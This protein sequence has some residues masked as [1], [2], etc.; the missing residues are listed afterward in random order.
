MCQK[1]PHFLRND[2]SLLEGF[3]MRVRRQIFSSL[4]ACF[5]LCA[6]VLLLSSVAPV[7]AQSTSTGTVV[8]NVTDPSGAVVSG[9][10][11][12]LTNTSTK[13]ART[14]PTNQAGRYIFVDVDPGTYDLTISKQGFSTSKTQATVNV[15][16]ATTVNM[17]LQ[18]GGSNVVVEVTAAGTE[19]QTMNATVGNTVSSLELD[20]L[21]SLGRDT[22]TFIT[23]QPGVSPDGSVAGAV[24]DQSYFS[25]DGGNNTNDMDGSM[26]V[27]TASYAGD[28][29][30]GI[31]N[32]SNGV[33]AGATGVMPTPQDSVEEFKVN[34]AGQT[35]DFNSSAGAEVKVV[36]KRGTNAIHGTAYEYYRDN[37][38]SGNTWDNSFNK[39]GLPTF[40][41]SR[42]GFAAGGP[43]IPKDILGGR[44]YLFG[45]FEGFRYPNS[46]TINRNVPSPALIAGN[47]TD[48]TTGAVTSLLSIDPNHIGINPVVQQMWQKYEPHSNANCVLSLCDGVNILGYS[49]NVSL[50]QKSNFAVGRLDHDFSD[51]WH[52]MTSYRYYNLSHAT[53]DQVDI[54]GFF[55]GDKLG[56][57][58]SQSSDPQQAWYLVAGLTTNITTNTTNDIHYSFLRNWW[59][60]SRAGDTP[61]LPGLGGALE[62][63]AGESSTQGLA[64]FNVNTQNTRT[65][66]WDGHD[67]MIRDDLSMLKGNHLFQVGGTY[68]HNFNWHQRSDNGGGINFQPVYQMG[69]GGAGSGLSSDLSFCATSN[70]ANCGAL[71]AAALGIVSISQ[72]AYTRSGANLALNPPLTPAS[73]QVTIPYYNVYFSDTW[74]M[75]PSFTLTYGLGWALEMPPVEAQGKQVELVDQNDAP[76]SAEDFLAA[77]K[78]AALLGNVFNPQVGFA[79]VGNTGGGLKYPYNPFYGEFSPRIA[80]AWNPHFDSSSM[81][82]KVF[83]SQETVIR[84]GYGRVY[85]RLNGVDLVLVP[86]LGTGLIQPVQ[87]LNNLA[88]G[89][90]GTC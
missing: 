84:G 38:W 25:L 53:T 64:P 46:Q 56:T 55:P 81:M 27:Y 66:F 3:A 15:G 50:P 47:L 79:L 71:T 80:A 63:M 18:V 77:R 19:L 41:Y 74:H 51:K 4:F 37:N 83:G 48:P 58:S 7:M 82:G 30:G 8:G 76:I 90:A 60:W 69:L 31:S 42:F 54:G 75:K 23:L 88:A 45:N 87:C 14:Q 29:T 10:T 44:T 43:I 32:Q 68:Q 67:Q 21:P 11:V 35:A 34:T 61:Q 9:A 52:F 6:V 26:S 2:S 78:R 62:V 59:S 85:G 33:A 89:S 39:V 36:T 24:V 17:A 13:T 65:R 12:T 5:L 28:P 72:I 20:S 49:A 86:L 40:H 16:N 1:S 57:P 70:I 22:S 73:D